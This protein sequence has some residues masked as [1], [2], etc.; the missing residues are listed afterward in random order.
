MTW[1]N[2]KDGNQP[3]TTYATREQDVTRAWHVIDAAGRPL[4]RVATEAATLLRG[5]HKPIFSPSVDAG[6]Y[7][8]IVN[9][10]NVAVT[11]RKITDKMYYRHSGYPGGLREQPLGRLLATH[12]ERVLERAVRGMLPKNRLGR[13]QY[14]H[15]R[16]YPRAVHPHQGQVVAARQGA[17]T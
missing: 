2:W 6:D 4:G 12:P 11:G 10:A 8:I 15:L 9:A 3:M 16:V 1:R 7:V 14:R 17:Q 5:K 13:Q